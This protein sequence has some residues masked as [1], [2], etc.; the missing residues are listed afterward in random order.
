M[1]NRSYELSEP[2]SPKLAARLCSITEAKYEKD[3]DSTV[4]THHFTELFY[5]LR[6]KG[7]FQVGNTLFSIKENDLIIVNSGIPHT[8]SSDLTE[9]LEYIALGIDNLELQTPDNT[10]Y[11][12]HNFSHY[13]EELD[14]YLKA[15]LREV[16]VQEDNYENICHN[17]FEILLMHIMR[18]TKEDFAAST[19]KKATKECRFIEQYLKDHFKEDI[20]LQDL[21]D[22]TFLNKYYLVHAFK[23]YKG[24]SPINYLI[25]VRINE[26]KRLLETTNY[27]I[28]KIA[29]LTGFSSQSYFSQT[30]RKMTDQTPKDYRKSSDIR[31]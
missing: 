15:L 9:P 6:G 25:L 28:A 12:I 29:T 13:R 26:A 4:H 31:K 3:W 11:S 27:S 8:E 7:K 21:S 10:G 16:R 19:S 17:L 18:R 23:N 5:I 1:S 14:T 2:Q 22:L 20:T 24:M 30:F